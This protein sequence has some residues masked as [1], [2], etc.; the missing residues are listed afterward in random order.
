MR[1]LLNPSLYFPLNCKSV[2]LCGGPEISRSSSHWGHSSHTHTHTHRTHT[3]ERNRLL[4]YSF[5]PT[6]FFLTKLSYFLCLSLS[7]SSIFCFLYF[8]SLLCFCLLPFYVELLTFC[9]YFSKLFCILVIFFSF[10]EFSA[11]LYF[12][13]SFFLST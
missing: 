2:E 12:L 11:S 13:R 4:S 3:T 10:A 5:Y 6:S 8:L 9:I 1:H 7:F